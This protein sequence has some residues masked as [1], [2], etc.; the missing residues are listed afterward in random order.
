MAGP[1]LTAHSWK[2][3]LLF[4]MQAFGPEIVSQEGAIK[5][6]IFRD[7]S[8]IGMLFFTTW[9]SSRDQCRKFAFHYKDKAHGLYTIRVFEEE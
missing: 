5:C 1:G 7:N 2:D 8:E 3:T 9:Y 6:T 4:S